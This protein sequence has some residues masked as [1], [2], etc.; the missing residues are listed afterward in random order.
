MSSFEVTAPDGKLYAVDAPEGATQEQ[1]LEHFK[2]NWK[3]EESN[4]VVEYGKDVLS[5]VSNL[6]AGIAKGAVRPLQMIGEH[7]APETTENVSQEPIHTSMIY[8]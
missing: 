3:P 7:V 4:P 1:A 8:S 5:N 2:A 6:Y